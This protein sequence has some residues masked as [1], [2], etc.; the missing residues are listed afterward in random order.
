MSSADR[1]EDFRH[2]LVNIGR[3]C[4]QEFKI[5]NR[6]FDGPVSVRFQETLVERT[7]HDSA[8]GVQAHLEQILCPP[9]DDDSIEDREQYM[10][11][12]CKAVSLLSDLAQE[13]ERH[14]RSAA[15][16]HD[17]VLKPEYIQ[18]HIATLFLMHKQNVYRMETTLAKSQADDILQHVAYPQVPTKSSNRLSLR[19]TARTEGVVEA[20]SSIKKK[21]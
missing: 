11:V 6:I 4:R 20:L 9:T 13:V 18:R 2:L 12:V 8:F 3:C 19:S 1:K 17:F 16:K 15:T 14:S 10:D 7:L 5:L 21:S